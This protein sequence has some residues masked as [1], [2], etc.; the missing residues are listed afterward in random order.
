[1]SEAREAELLVKSGEPGM[2]E[3]LKTV[4][5]EL[6]KSKEAAKAAKLAKS[7]FLANM[8]HEIRTPL[9]GVIGMTDL[10]LDTRLGADQRDYC[11]TIKQSADALLHVLSD[12]L[13]F[14]K[15]EAGNL[16]LAQDSFVLADFLNDLLVAFAPRAEQKKLSL[17]LFLPPE[18]HR[19][20]LGDS[21]RLRQVLSNLLDNAIKFSAGGEIRLSVAVDSSQ[22]APGDALSL[23][24]SVNDN[25]V[26]I[27][28]EKQDSIFDPFVQVDSSST[29]RFGGTGLGLSISSQIV[30]LM[31]GKLWVESE[32]NHGSTFHF[33]LSFKVSEKSKKLPPP[34]F[35][36]HPL[37]PLRILLAEDNPINQK[38]VM[39]ILEKR[40]HSV[41]L[42][43]DGQQALSLWE[44][45]P[46]DL[47]LMD[48]SMPVMDGLEVTAQIRKK[49]KSHTPIVALTAH[50]LKGDVARCF[51]AGMDGYVPKPVD[52]IKLFREMA[53]V[54]DLDQRLT[55][56]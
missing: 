36:T 10:L 25:G 8:S 1:M 42:A 47:I 46:V 56:I 7:R 49:E 33:T 12:I 32:Q 2:T 19:S 30:A 14:A 52:R 38:V 41:F 35:E 44:R 5:A 31:G 40:G 15:L 4:F 16:D 51:S 11:Q 27:P 22:K 34:E 50:V 18:A 53:R 23:R 45:V 48:V 55:A 6:T 17:F 54:L 21:G 37:P 20:L 39:R 28:R 26:G 29:R 9:N 3:L 24:F 13:D 43:E